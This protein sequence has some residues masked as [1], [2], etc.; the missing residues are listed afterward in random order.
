MSQI[1]PLNVAEYQEQARKVLTHNAYSYYVSGARD[2]ITLREN[3]DAFK[4]IFI[5]PRFLR[6]VAR[7]DCSTTILGENVSSPILIAPCA[8]HKLATAGMF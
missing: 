7:V 6:N 2:E 4:R 5:M 8:M 3:E 1:K